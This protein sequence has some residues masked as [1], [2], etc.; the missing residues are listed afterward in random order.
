MTDGGATRRR[1]LSV[2]GGGALAAAALGSRADARSARN[3]DRD[4]FQSGRVDVAL[5]VLTPR[6]RRARAETLL[7]AHEGGA[8]AADLP[9]FARAEP[10]DRLPIGGSGLIGSVFRDLPYHTFLE[11]ENLIGR[12]VLAGDVLVAD[13]RGFG[14]QADT[15]RVLLRRPVALLSKPPLDNRPIAFTLQLGFRDA[16]PPAGGAGVEVGGVYA[17]RGALLLSPPYESFYGARLF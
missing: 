11:R 15:A 9:R 10:D 1:A 17:A 2:I 7:V 4:D 14:V 5:R 13:L 12:L 6:G 16:A 3:D 8:A